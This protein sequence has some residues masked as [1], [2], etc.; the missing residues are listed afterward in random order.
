M[1]PPIEVV[2]SYSS[3]IDEPT[4]RSMMNPISNNHPS[5]LSGGPGAKVTHPPNPG[6]VQ[7]AHI[8]DTTTPRRPQ[9]VHSPDRQ[10]CMVNGKCL[11]LHRHMGVA[12]DNLMVHQS[13]SISRL[14]AQLVSILFLFHIHSF[15][16]PRFLLLVYLK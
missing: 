2:F 12:G 16:S 3:P 6:L 8:C 4:P 15:I 7:S 1:Q 10:P 9:T 11:N 13:L 5:N 14:I